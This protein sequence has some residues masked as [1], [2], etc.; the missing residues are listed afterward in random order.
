MYNK[1]SFATIVLA[2]MAMFDGIQGIDALRETSF[3]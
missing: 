3:P 2:C 1:L